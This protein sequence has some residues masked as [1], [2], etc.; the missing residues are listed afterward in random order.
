MFLFFFQF[1][2]FSD[3]ILLNCIFFHFCFGGTGVRSQGFVF[4]KQ[5]PHL[6]LFSSGYF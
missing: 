3:I 2:K 1:G 4:A 5:V 6:Q